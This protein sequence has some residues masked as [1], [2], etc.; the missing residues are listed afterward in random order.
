MLRWKAS[1]P[2]PPEFHFELEAGRD[3]EFTASRLIYRGRDTAT[4]VSG[5]LEGT[6]WYRVRVGGGEDS[7]PWSEPLRLEVH[8]IDRGRVW[9][10]MGAGTLGFLATAGA[11]LAGHRRVRLQ[12]LEK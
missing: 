4:L 11:L 2:L 7:R 5:L 10:L 12:R 3:R 9:L 1:S 6:H 8:Y